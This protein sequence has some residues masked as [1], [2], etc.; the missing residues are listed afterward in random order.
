MSDEEDEALHAYQHDA[1]EDF[2]MGRYP[3]HIPEA[4]MAPSNVPT[5][6]IK[7]LKGAAAVSVVQP[8]ISARIEGALIKM[9]SSAEAL[10]CAL[11]TLLDFLDIRRSLPSSLNLDARRILDAISPA[12]GLLEPEARRLHLDWMGPTTEVLWERVERTRDLLAKKHGLG[13]LK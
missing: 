10:Y 7:A 13:G 6:W 4:Y 11:A 1:L 2:L 3:Y 12:I 9:T 8:D 5:N